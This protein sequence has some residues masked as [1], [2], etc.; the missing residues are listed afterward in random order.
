MMKK[1]ITC[2]LAI[3]FILGIFGNT[4]PA[5]AAAAKP[6]KAKLTAEA[7]SDGKSVTLSI[8][9]TKNAEG[10]KIM[11]KKPG[12]DKYVKLTTLKQDGTEK[13]TYTAKKLAAGEYE[14]KVRAYTNNGSKTV[15]GK[16]SKAVSVTVGTVSAAGSAK[17]IEL[18]YIT[19]EQ[20]KIE[21]EYLIFD[22][23]PNVYIVPG[24]AEKADE[25]FRTM[26][27][28][29]GRSVKDGKY[30]TGKINVIVSRYESNN[31]LAENAG[32]TMGGDDT[33]W[34]APSDLFIEDGYAFTHEL[35]HTFNREFTGGFA[36]TVLDEGFTTYTELKIMD[37]LAEKDPNLGAMLGSSDKV[38]YNM[39][40]D[41]YEVMYEKSVEYWIKH[42][43]EAYDFC[44]N[45]G[46]GL[47][48]R[49]MGYL[50]EKFGDYTSWFENYDEIA[51]ARAKSSGVDLI[52]ELEEKTIANLA[53]RALKNTYG[54]IVLDDFY[55]W[56]QENE[57]G[58]FDT[59]DYYEKSNAFASV[60]EFTVYPF[61][62]WAENRTKI[63]GAEK[64]EY[65]DLKVNI[66]P[67][68]FYL[69]EYK[70]ED[71]S[72]LILNVSEGTTVELY[73]IDGKLLDTVKNTQIPLTGV[74][75]V[76]LAGKGET[77]FTITG[78]HIYDYGYH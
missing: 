4:R 74:A 51:A 76:K 32:P 34:L 9:K 6:A 52:D 61:Y 22:I 78:Y 17:T 58:R 25:V 20:T 41:D 45:G 67:A 60:T 73:D 29:T 33:L 1:L 63:P 53:I 62:W 13:R 71:T 49:L 21:T 65:N 27:T 8:A 59:D 42:A 68:E 14:F 56:M 26:E 37:L 10:Y 5:A 15:W 23:E 18:G 16:Y 64:T 57:Y 19:K 35:G 7:G 70:G 54:E 43:D 36:G 39:T 28:V 48:F 44:W 11:V 55:A 47:G 3:A 75:S 77:I 40:I 46:Y 12:S 50:E 31:T 66:A 24:L 30:H 72:N 38:R 69:R 2:L